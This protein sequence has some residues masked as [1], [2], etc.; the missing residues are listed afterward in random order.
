MTDDVLVSCP[1]CRADFPV[2]VLVRVLT[3]CPACLHTCALDDAH[4]A[5]VATTPEVDELTRTELDYL[6]SQKKKARTILAKAGG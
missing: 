2:L 6:R 1:W 3:I 5:R 4:R